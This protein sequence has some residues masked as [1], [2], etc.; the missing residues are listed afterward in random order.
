MDGVIEVKKEDVLKQDIPE[1]DFMNDPDLHESEWT[2]EHKKLKAEYEKR[3]KQL[4]EDRAKHKKGLETELKKLQQMVKDSIA[5]FDV[6]LTDLYQKRILISAA[7]HQEEL[8]LKRLNRS[9][10]WSDQT[11]IAREEVEKL[12]EDYRTTK[13][14]KSKKISAWRMAAEHAKQH[15]ETQ[16]LEEK[17]LERQFKVTK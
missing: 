7:I 13:Q 5:N 8:K 4:A 9:I 16:V 11:K 15:L 10:E 1:P 17:T 12:V 2:D 6:G 3:V 14:E